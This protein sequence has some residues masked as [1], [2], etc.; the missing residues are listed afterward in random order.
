[1]TIKRIRKK[2]YVAARIRQHWAVTAE[3]ARAKLAARKQE[4]GR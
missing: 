3:M 1:M 2:Q 4:E